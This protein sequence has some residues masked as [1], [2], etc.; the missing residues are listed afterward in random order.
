MADHNI[1]IVEN[2]GIVALDLKRRIHRMGYNPVIALSGRD[3]IRVAR[4]T[5]PTVGILD[6]RLE[7]DLDGIETA[8]ILLEEFSISIIY[9]SALID[10]DTKQRAKSTH[11]IKYI[12]KPFNDDDL[13]SALVEAVKLA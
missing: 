2:E 7:G 11:P 3:A 1:L 9:I 4:E 10:D 8:T 6:I 12:E 13:Q 5:C